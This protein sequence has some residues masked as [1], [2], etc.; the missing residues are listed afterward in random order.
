MDEET[1]STVFDPLH[2]IMWRFRLMHVTLKT[3]NHRATKAG[4][5]DHGFVGRTTELLC[6]IAGYKWISGCPIR[7]VVNQKSTGVVRRRSRIE[8]FYLGLS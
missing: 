1:L 2:I 8:H 4:S 5:E 3:G 7:W 6:A